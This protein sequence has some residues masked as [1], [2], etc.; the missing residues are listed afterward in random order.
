MKYKLII[1]D[2]VEFDVKGVINGRQAKPFKFKL[3]AA[4]ISTEQYRAGV[5]EDRSIRDVLVEHVR[6]WDGQQLV[7]TEDDQPADFTAEALEALLG[8]Y[9]MEQYIWVAYLQALAVGETAAG[10]AKN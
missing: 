9:G 8:I 1:D 6:G 3:T 10:R 2:V 5:A 7:F 4:R